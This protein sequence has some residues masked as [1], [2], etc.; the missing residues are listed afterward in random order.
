VSAIRGDLPRASRSRS[1]RNWI[2]PLPDC[3]PGPAVGEPLAAG[4][5]HPGEKKVQKRFENISGV[6][7]IDLVGQSKREVKVN[8]DPLRLEALG[9]GVDEV[10]A[11]LQS[12]NVNTRSGG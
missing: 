3:F 8:I 1:S 5:D 2:L 10:I 4:P 11:G 9:M 12:E 6:G 7:K